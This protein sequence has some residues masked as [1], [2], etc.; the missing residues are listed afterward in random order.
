MN[1]KWKAVF[2]I[3]FG[4]AIAVAVLLLNDR[5]AALGNYG[6]LGAADAENCK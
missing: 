1:E 5:I 2:Q 4:I 3:L 6:Y